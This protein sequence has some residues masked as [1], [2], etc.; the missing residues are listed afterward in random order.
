MLG[1][2][3]THRC[4]TSG[5]NLEAS[6]RSCSRPVSSPDS[7][8]CFKGLGELPAHSLDVSPPCLPAVGTVH[9]FHG[10]LGPIRGWFLHGFLG[11]DPCCFT[12]FTALSARVSSNSCQLLI[13]N[14]GCRSM[15][16]SSSILKLVT[17][18]TAGTHTGLLFR[19]ENLIFHA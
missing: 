3:T 5:R 10:F 14:H 19:I 9:I 11:P 12:F 16:G 18:H 17:S 1:L 15:N 2:H 8:N 4:K 6:P 7:L 13:Q